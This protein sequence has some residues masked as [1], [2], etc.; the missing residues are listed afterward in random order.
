MK[1]S[2]ESYTGGTS[3]RGLQPPPAVSSEKVLIVDSHAPSCPDVVCLK[4]RRDGHTLGQIVLTPVRLTT[5][6]STIGGMAIELL[7]THQDDKDI[8]AMLVHKSFELLR[9]QGCPFVVVAGMADYYT[10]LGFECA[11]N[12]N[13]VYD[14]HTTTE[15][16]FMIRFLSHLP[17][18]SIS[19]TVQY[20]KQLD[21][22]CN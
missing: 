9:K 2:H 7:W 5:N 6:K 16:S 11:L 15:Q 19:G 1:V 3:I 13:I 22:Y 12:Y 21:C 10:R 8:A 17:D 14:P 18:R 4:A 20:S